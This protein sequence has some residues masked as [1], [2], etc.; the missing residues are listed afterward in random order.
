MNPLSHLLHSAVKHHVDLLLTGIIG[1]MW[2]LQAIPRET[3]GTF[4]M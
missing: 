1:Q 4:M 2:R 3:T